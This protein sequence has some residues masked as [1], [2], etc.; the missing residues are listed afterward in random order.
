MTFNLINKHGIYH[1]YAWLREHS[2]I[3]SNLDRIKSVCYAM[4]LKSVHADLAILLDSLQSIAEYDGEP[5]FY[6]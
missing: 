4:S 3:L 2:E 6:W 5:L 1:D